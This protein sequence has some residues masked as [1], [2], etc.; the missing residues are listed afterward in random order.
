MSHGKK[1]IQSAI[2]NGQPASLRQVSQALFLETE[3]PLWQFVQNHYASH[4]SLPDLAVLS[5]AGFHFTGAEPEQPVSYYLERLRSRFIFNTVADRMQTLTGA[6]EAQD[7]GSVVEILRDTLASVGTAASGHTATLM[8]DE[9]DRV[10]EDYLIAKTT[11]GLRGM[12]LGWD[13]LDIETLGAMA[14]DLIVIAGRPGLGKTNA[15]LHMARASWK[16]NH[17][18]LFMS[19]EMGKLQ[20]ARRFLGM[21]SGINPNLIRAGELSQ[22]GEQI[23]YDGVNQIKNALGKVYLE[24]GDFHRSVGGIEAM[25]LQ[26]NPEAVYV[27]AA[28]LLSPEGITKGYVSRWESISE[29]V[30]QLKELALRYNIPVF[31]SVQFNRN[32]RGKSTSEPDL[33]DIAGADSIPQDA[34]I[35]LGIQKAPAP[36]SEVRRMMVMMKNREGDLGKLLYNYRFNPVNFEEIPFI[37]DEEEQ[38]HQTVSLDWMV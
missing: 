10:L 23:M 7:T 34:S 6:M 19:M 2:L 37:E 20:I 25:I 29:T 36:F 18:T 26:F 1:F 12:T 16:A 17:R 21:E 22:W 30:R 24:A 33:A 32:Q 11:T 28:Y 31:I 5:E 9:M 35:V 38:Q 13:T 8:G 3:L 15:L 27:D 14:G 4:A